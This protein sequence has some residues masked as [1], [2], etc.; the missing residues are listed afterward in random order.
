MNCFIENE[1]LLNLLLNYGSLVLFSALILGIIALPIPEETLMV[2]AGAFMNQ[3]ILLI[4]STLL[5][6]YLGSMIGITVSYYLGKTGGKY[7]ILKHGKWV[8]ITEKHFEKAKNWFQHYGKWSLFVGYFIPGVRHFTGLTA[9]TTDVEYKQFALYAYSGALVWV[10]TFLSVGYFFGKYCFTILEMLDRQ[11]VL[12]IIAAVVC[13]IVY[14]YFK[15]MR[16]PG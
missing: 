2:F 9:G 7:I 11:I 15:V 6:A 5:A 1:L 13:L 4:P 3:G 8:G 16:K 10:T 14:Y 12:I